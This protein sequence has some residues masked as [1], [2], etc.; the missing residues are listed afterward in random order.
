MLPGC[1]VIQ[2][3]ELGLGMDRNQDVLGMQVAEAHPPPVGLLQLV[4]FFIIS[5]C[6]IH[7]H[8]GPIPHMASGGRLSYVQL[9]S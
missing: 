2:K 7:L 8:S 4:F 1:G 6:F 9:G 5:S 3:L